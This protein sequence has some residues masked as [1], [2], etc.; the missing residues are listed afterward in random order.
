MKY[1]KYC[2]TST[3]LSLHFYQTKKITHSQVSEPQPQ[4]RKQIAHLSL[5]YFSCC[6]QHPNQRGRGAGLWTLGRGNRSPDV[7]GRAAPQPSRLQDARRPL[8]GAQDGAPAVGT[9]PRTCHPPYGC[10]APRRCRTWCLPAA[11]LA[12]S[13]ASSRRRGRGAAQEGGK[14]K[15]TILQKYMV[16]HNF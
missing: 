7:R 11:A 4:F 10:T 3:L 1:L 12:G 5:E 15:I 8:P 14:G 13:R 6:S 2:G 16:R 9:R